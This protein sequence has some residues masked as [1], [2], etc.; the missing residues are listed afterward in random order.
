MEDEEGVVKLDSRGIYVP[1][2]NKSSD[3]D[4]N[5][6]SRG[7]LNTEQNKERLKLHALRNALGKPSIDDIVAHWYKEYDITMNPRSE[8]EWADNHE[9]EILDLQQTMER[10][11]EIEVV[12]SSN[13]ALT[14]TLAH[15]AKKKVTVIEKSHKELFKAYDA[16]TA[17]RDIF[18][19][20]GITKEQFF[21]LKGD[22]KREVRKDIDLIMKMRKL[23]IEEIKEFSTVSSEHAKDL[24]AFIA[25]AK[26]INGTD[27]ILDKRMKDAIRLDKKRKR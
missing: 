8:R 4:P 19:V 16:L 23:N 17:T 26:D 15:G 7:K 3:N 21:D 9:L 12:H 14:N 10:N 13:T 2:I 24:K 5:K 1:N 25:L 20:V 18:N 6:G 27:A 22:E 11:G